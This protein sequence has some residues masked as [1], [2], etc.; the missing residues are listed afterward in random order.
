MGSGLWWS[1]WR[2]AAIAGLALLLVAV[3]VQVEAGVAHAPAS[4]TVVAWGKND[5]GELGDGTLTSRAEPA[6]VGGLDDVVATDGGG[7]YSLALKADGTVWAWG[8][9]DGGVLGS[10]DLSPSATPIRVVGLDGV[11]G[12]S[13]GVVHSLA[14]KEDGTVWAWGYNHSFQLGVSLAE[15]PCGGS[16]PCSPTPVQVA[17]LGP[18]AAVAAGSTHSLAL[19]RDGS[20]WTWGQNDVGQAGVPPGAPCQFSHTPC[21]PSPV[22]VPG[23]AEV[24]AVAVGFNHSLAVKDDGTVW[25]WGLNKNGQLG[26][27]TTTSSSTP[28]QVGGLSG[29][30]TVAGG[31]LHSLALKEDGTVW[32]WGWAPTDQGAQDT[33]TAGQLPGLTEVVALAA[34]DAQSLALKADGTVWFWGVRALGV[35]S[36]DSLKQVSPTQVAGLEGAIAVASG[37]YHSLSLTTAATAGESAAANPSTLPATGQGPELPLWA[38]LGAGAALLILGLAARRGRLLV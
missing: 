15:S 21:V 27:G 1:E 6:P 37:S 11:A 28:V 34:G 9:N 2:L 5:A 32:A 4:G 25:A 20:V 30:K 35:G 24:V 16:K 38:A 7:G 8:G 33:L 23:L 36:R 12:I 10:G 13:A 26:D 31:N 29:V 19:L 14:L 3:P 17:G 18:A 22:Q